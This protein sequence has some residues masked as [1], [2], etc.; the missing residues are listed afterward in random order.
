M[1]APTF[2]PPD[3]NILLDEV[4]Q[5]SSL[6]DE[7]SLKYSEFGSYLQVGEIKNTSGWILHISVVI[8]QVSQLITSII[9]SLTSA[10]IPF[11]IPEDKVHA[12][13]IL[14]GALGFEM[15]GKVVTIY[16]DS[17]ETA[18]NIANELIEI[19]RDF[20]GP[21]VLTD[22][23]LGGCVYCRHGA[24]KQIISIDKNGK[25]K[26]FYLGEQERLIEDIQP[27]PFRYNP[28]LMWPFD[29]SPQSDRKKN[30]PKM[31]FI[32]TK[33]L[34]Q[35]GKGSVF[36]CI[37]RHFGMIPIV[38]IVKR[39]ERH[40]IS[41]SKNLDICDRLK[42][43]FILLNKLKS[44][45]K[46][47]KP[48]A[49]IE[50]DDAA[51]L[52]IKK[53]NG[54]TLL[55]EMRLINK[56]Q[57][58]FF[59]LSKKQKIQIIDLLSQV[60]STTSELHN[61]LII[62]RD[63]TP[64]NYM[65]SKRKIVHLIDLEYA[66]SMVEDYPTPPFE[67]GTKGYMSPEQIAVKKPTPKED[68]YGLSATILHCVTGISPLTIP[69]SNPEDTERT[70]FF[71][72]K[73]STFSKLCTR[74]LSKHPEERPT[75]NSLSTCLKNLVNEKNH[76]QE[77]RSFTSLNNELK[78]GFIQS[79]I[80]ALGK[81]PLYDNKNKYWTTSVGYQSLQNEEILE[82][83]VLQNYYYGIFG[84]TY[85]IDLA[86]QLKFDTTPLYD[87]YQRNLSYAV[88]LTF[89]NKPN[90]ELS[91]DFIGMCI[92]IT[93]SIK[94][95]HLTDN[96]SNRNLLLKC[97]PQKSN[98][99]TIGSG[100]SGLGLLLLRNS[101]YFPAEK[102]QSTLRNIIKQI[103][104]NVNSDQNWLKCSKTKLSNIS[105]SI[106]QGK[107][108]ITYFLLNYL[109][110]FEDAE[111]RKTVLKY[112]DSLDILIKR[113]ILKFSQKGMSQIYG[114]GYQ[115]SENTLS[116]GKIL[117]CA[118]EVLKDSTYTDIFESI[119]SSFPNCI[120]SDNFS[121]NTGLCGL[122]EL[123]LA[124]YESTN[125]KLWKTKAEWIIDL[126]YNCHKSTVD[127]A[128]FWTGNNRSNPLPGLIN[129]SAG[130]IHLFLKYS[131]PKEIGFPECE[132]SIQANRLP[133]PIENINHI[134]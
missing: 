128:L 132:K 8:T 6:L 56:N 41:N 61:Q 121:Q 103:F 110:Q 12:S 100:L 119:F 64:V 30:L 73:S 20:F 52:V 4:I 88:N 76:P 65:V 117:I 72:T 124:A 91:R 31:P 113:K 10:K 86:K 133:F 22:F 74:G 90:N 123:Y 11:R 14:D 99:L 98:D 32:P 71:L 62:H 34:Q 75:I 49:F 16:P 94:A 115:V 19:T 45:L 112:L 37:Y 70:I 126:V 129:G 26:T 114:E 120:S 55:E 25:R 44:K 5:Y 1:E 50:R 79:C 118:A 66:H 131:F 13:M 63:V 111:V 51:F 47:S 36:E 28:R 87:I 84:I 53:I 82:H 102:T 83:T 95:G 81:D 60:C 106:Y 104:E 27:I 54:K 93:S 7:H 108:G 2:I 9:P 15:I 42:W 24:H 116:I 43:Q 58:A 57:L 46:L 69:I 21:K 122:G 17:T 101:E 77:L 40:M 127:G 35:S 33:L 134:V 97:L 85:I 125:N 109:S 39:G 96:E 78:H 105:E 48:Y 67:L 130:I 68:I 3:S 38:A 18:R 89:S 80:Y 107:L 59:D 92:A 23:H 29:Q